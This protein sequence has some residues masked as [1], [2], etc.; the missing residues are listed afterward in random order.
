MLITAVIVPFRDI[1]PAY[2]GPQLIGEQHLP[3]D[4]KRLDVDY[5]DQLRLVGYRGA[6]SPA[7]SD[8]VEFTLYWQCLKPIMTDYSVFVIVY[9]RQLQEVGKRDAYPYHGLYAT[10]Q[11]QPGQLF[12]DPYQVPIAAAEANRPAVLR[13]QIGVKDW[14]TGMELTPN[15]NGA[16]VSAVM[17]SVGKL[18]GTPQPER[19]RT[20][21]YRL[22][23][24]ITLLDARMERGE[25]GA[26][27]SLTWQA[28]ATPPEAY[29]TFVHVLDA[30]GKLIGQA[31]GPPLG[32]DYP[33]DWWSPGE[34]IIDERPLPLPPEADRVTIGLYRLS[35]GMRLPVVDGAGQRVPNDEIVLPVKP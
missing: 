3:P 32:G 16:A 2:A 28:A 9:G 6:E 24:G 13:A 31:D 20:M 27:L 23:D 18:A 5:G 4:L 34:T 19:D 15:A 17:L 12:A 7:R 14:A 26:L 10:R 21:N 35:D 29:T 30:D 25:S 1:A 8:S 22:G 33:T 11:C